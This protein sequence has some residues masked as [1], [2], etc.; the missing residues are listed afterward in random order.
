M[1]FCATIVIVSATKMNIFLVS[2]T[3]DTDNGPSYTGK[4][5]PHHYHNGIDPSMPHSG[6]LY[7][8]IYNW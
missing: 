1:D 2:I 4:Y 8:Q 3:Y 6:D 7:D 5:I